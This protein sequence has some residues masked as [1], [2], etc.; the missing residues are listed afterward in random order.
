M[1]TRQTEDRHRDLEIYGERLKERREK[2][3]IQIE[4]ERDIE[5]GFRESVCVCVRE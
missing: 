3:E 1:T 5:R 4:I 2:D